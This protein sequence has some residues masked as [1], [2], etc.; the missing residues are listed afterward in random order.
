M[1]IAV[2]GCGGAGKS[3]LAMELAAATG[4]VVVAL[5]DFTAPGTPTWEHARF[6]SEVLV[7]FR[8]RGAARYRPHRW[9]S[10]TPGAERPIDH[11]PLIVEGV[12]A[13]AEEAVMLADGPWWDLAVWVDADEV[14]RRQRI[15]QRD[16]EAVQDT[17]RDQWWPSE[18]AYVAAQDPQRRADIVITT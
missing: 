18:E 1:V 4:G 10:P 6:L 7:P 9:D 5:D 3:T 13:L 2:D 8:A 17:W 11:G 16:P 15:R 12:S 14:T